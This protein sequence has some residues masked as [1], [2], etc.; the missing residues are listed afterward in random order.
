MV[1]CY[2]AF[3]VGTM[4]LF[5]ER[6]RLP[7]HATRRRA[8]WVTAVVAVHLATVNCFAFCAFFEFV[9]TPEANCPADSG[10]AGGESELLRCGRAYLLS[11]Y[12]PLVSLLYVTA[13]YPAAVAFFPEVRERA[14]KPRHVSC[15]HARA[16]YFLRT[17]VE[18][19]H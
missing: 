13:Q 4:V 19:A 11:V 6:K 9:L 17:Q 3:T 1:R 7:A 12:A 8:M 10:G 2:T 5:F 18:P 16:R 15:T 14:A